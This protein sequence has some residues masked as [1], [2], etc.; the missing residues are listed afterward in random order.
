P[1]SYETASREGALADAELAR[2][3]KN[4][5][6]IASDDGAILPPHAPPFLPSPEYGGGL[7]F[8]WCF[9][10]RR[11]LPQPEH[12][13]FRPAPVLD[14]LAVAYAAIDVKMPVG[15]GIIAMGVAAGEVAV[16]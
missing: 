11:G 16:D 2:S 10:V 4:H 7:V 13:D 14:A 12:R 6:G 5:V 9:N 3:A 1:D 8:D 15:D